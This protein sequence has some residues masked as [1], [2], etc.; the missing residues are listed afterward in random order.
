MVNDIVRT[1]EMVM[2][3]KGKPRHNPPTPSSRTTSAARRG[4]EVDSRDDCSR[5]LSESSCTVS[6]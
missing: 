2:R 6:I 1:M 4:R 3:G 5:D